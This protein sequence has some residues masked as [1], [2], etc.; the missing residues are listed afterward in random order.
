MGWGERVGGLRS[1]LETN[2]IVPCSYRMDFHFKLKRYGEKLPCF[3]KR[4]NFIFSDD[5]EYM[6]KSN[7]FG[8]K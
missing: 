8:V 1:H 7:S 2:N 4:R 3:K 5:T 6:V